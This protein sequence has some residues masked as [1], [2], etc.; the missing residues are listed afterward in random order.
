MYILLLLLAEMVWITADQYQID[1]SCQKHESTKTP[2]V[3]CVFYFVLIEC[4][5][6][7]S[8]NNSIELEKGQIHSGITL[9]VF[10]MSESPKFHQTTKNTNLVSKK[11]KIG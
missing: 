11:G 6:N 3:A 1:V 9:T 10:A 4:D 5:K 8:T 2:L 7:N